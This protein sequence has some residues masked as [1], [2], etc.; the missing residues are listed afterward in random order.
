MQILGIIGGGVGGCKLLNILSK[1]AKIKWISDT[2]D[3]APGIILA[4]SLGIEIVK[5]FVP[6]ISNPA[7][8]LVIEC[9]GN[10]KVLGLIDEK[11]SKNLS[12]IS[13]EGALLLV[14]MTEE[15]QKA[16]EIQKMNAKS[17]VEQS[18]N[19]ESTV[20][21]LNEAGH[22]IKTRATLVSSETEQVENAVVNLD[23]SISI[24]GNSVRAIK[25]NFSSITD[26]AEEMSSTATEI[27]NN[28]SFISTLTQKAVNN[29]LQA[30]YWVKNLQK[31]AGGIDKI[32]EFI[33]DV[34]EQTDLLALNAS[35]QAARAGDS[36]KGFGVVAGEVK[37]LARQTQSASANAKSEIEQMFDAVYGTM[38]EI[39]HIT[40]MIN[41]IN[42]SM[43]AIASAIEE[44]SATTREV[45]ESIN[46][47]FTDLS[48]LS[49]EITM[50][51]DSSK[52]VSQSIISIDKEI[53][54][55][56]IIADDF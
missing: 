22:E 28:T 41:E 51:A 16:L 56:V 52:I 39:S 9:T 29:S 24:I 14:T 10:K 35:I 3:N 55:L 30:D 32:I 49:S 54:S 38:K 37:D 23:S 46:V 45:S 34:A 15:I 31:A 36:G 40:E 7:I 27:S 47:G 25:S 21:K 53:K 26:A 19:L 50:V 20:K 12:I 48:A 33:I 17:L 6:Y 5:D 11:K 8:D 18:L 13:S 42:S 43:L 44:Q 1:I 4:K 2:N